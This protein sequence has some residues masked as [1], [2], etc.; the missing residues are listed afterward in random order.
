METDLILK[1]TN[2]ANLSKQVMHQES[3]IQGWLET[4]VTKKNIIKD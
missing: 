2:I 4:I 3:A 1:N